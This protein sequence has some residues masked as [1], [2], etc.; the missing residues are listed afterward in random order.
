MKEEKSKPQLSYIER[1]KLR[2]L[3]EVRLVPVNKVNTKRE[4][5]QGNLK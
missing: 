4:T 2:E 1:L 5:V 3:K